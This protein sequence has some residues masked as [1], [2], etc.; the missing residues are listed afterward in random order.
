MI[1]VQQKKAIF[2]PKLD[3]RMTDVPEFLLT[4]YQYQLYLLVL[5][6]SIVEE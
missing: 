4:V 6:I 2:V 5:V 3:K 1:D